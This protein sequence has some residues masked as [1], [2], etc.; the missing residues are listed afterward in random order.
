M[1]KLISDLVAVL[2]NTRSADLMANSPLQFTKFFAR[3]LM[4]FNG[5]ATGLRL[6]VLVGSEA[7]FDDVALNAVN[8]FPVNPDDYVYTTG[9]EPGDQIQV[10]LRNTTVADIDCQFQ[11][12][13][14]P[15][16]IGA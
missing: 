7:V 13:R 2:A 6:T 4:A 3:L 8:R 14:E 10:F 12:V 5:E 9:A 15:V 1:P 16:A 11:I